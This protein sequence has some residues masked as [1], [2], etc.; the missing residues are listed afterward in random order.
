MIGLVLCG[1]RDRWMAFQFTL[2][3]AAGVLAMWWDGY[4]W[5][6]RP[7]EKGLTLWGFIVG[8]AVSRAV[9]FLIVWARYGWAAARS[10]RMSG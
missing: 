3:V 4:L 2:S 5:G 7:G 9:M 1:L 10:M 8:L 6:A